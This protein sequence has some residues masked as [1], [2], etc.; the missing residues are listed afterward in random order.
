MTTVANFI[1]VVRDGSDDP[2]DWIGG[3]V[4]VA[5]DTV[6]D[7]TLTSG[8]YLNILAISDDGTCEVF[9]KVAE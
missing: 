3:S 6:A 2:G 4:N 5:G 7:A 8:K 1:N 9:S